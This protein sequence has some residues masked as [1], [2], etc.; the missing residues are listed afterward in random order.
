MPDKIKTAETVQ[1]TAYARTQ[2]PTG[3][4]SMKF[5]NGDVSLDKAIERNG[6]HV[7]VSN[8]NILFDT[9]W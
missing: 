8:V 1:G 2:E 9:S 5:G 3:S 6:G 4:Y 7:V